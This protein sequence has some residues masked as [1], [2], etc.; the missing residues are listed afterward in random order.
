MFVFAGEA[1][2]SGGG[3]E[4]GNT[5]SRVSLVF[6]PVGGEVEVENATG[7]ICDLYFESK[8]TCTSCNGYLPP[9]TAQNTKELKQRR[10]GR[11]RKR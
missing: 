9:S 11:Q 4:C 2:F 7:T 5:L 1:N 8:F 10:G 6:Q 3:V